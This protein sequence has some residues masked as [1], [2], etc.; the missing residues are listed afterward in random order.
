MQ[1]FSF[2]ELQGWYSLV[3]RLRWVC[4]GTTT[5]IMNHLP[6]GGLMSRLAVEAI[7][8]RDAAEFLQSSWLWDEGYAP[9]GWTL[10]MTVMV[11]SSV[12]D[13]LMASRTL[14]PGC[15]RKISDRI[16]RCKFDK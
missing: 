11:L 3:L 8:G 4:V 14:C 9:P 15:M 13:L 2:Q 10:G 12:D 16:Y 6:I 5:W 1:V 7:A